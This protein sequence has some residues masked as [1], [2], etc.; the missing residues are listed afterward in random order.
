MQARAQAVAVCVLIRLPISGDELPR[1][2]PFLL[3][4]VEPPRRCRGHFG[5]VCAAQYCAERNAHHA[6]PLLVFSKPNHRLDGTVLQ[7]QTA[8]LILVDGRGSLGAVMDRVIRTEFYLESDEIPSGI[9][10]DELPSV[11]VAWLRYP[12]S[13][14]DLERLSDFEPFPE[15]A[16]HRFDRFAEMEAALA[17]LLQEEMGPFGRVPPAVLEE[18]LRSQIVIERSPPS[19]EPFFGLLGKGAATLGTLLGINLAVEPGTAFVMLV[20]IP[21]GVIVVGSALG[22]IPGPADQD[23]YA[24]SRRPMDMMVHG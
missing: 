18:L 13:G 21:I 23:R 4:H 12:N 2:Q 14:I 8:G 20:T 24:Q 15:F 9:D 3:S 11:S 5:Y 10:P 22:V 1:R 16:N 17:R 6:L 19:S 7:G